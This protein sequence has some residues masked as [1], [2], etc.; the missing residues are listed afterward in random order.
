MQEGKTWKKAGDHTGERGKHG[1]HLVRRGAGKEKDESRNPKNGGNQGE[2]E[3]RGFGR[4]LRGGA[5]KMPPQIGRCTFRRGSLDE[6]R[7]A[8]TS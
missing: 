7:K 2:E 8:Q 5:T 3:R 4:F 6:C 1:F